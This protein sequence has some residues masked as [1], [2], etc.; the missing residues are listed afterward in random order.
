MQPGALVLGPIWPTS[1]VSYHGTSPWNLPSILDEGLC[2]RVCERKCDDRP[3]MG[4]I[5]MSVSQYKSAASWSQYGDAGY[6]K[7]VYEQCEPEQCHPLGWF[8]NAVLV[9]D[10][11]D[12]VEFVLGNMHTQPRFPICAIIELRTESQLKSLGRYITPFVGRFN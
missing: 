12:G 4:A 8:A 11:D 7:Y 5:A 6:L 1:N 9:F 2:P 3:K 10:D